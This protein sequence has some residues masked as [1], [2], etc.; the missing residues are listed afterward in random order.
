M[1]ALQSPGR[2][3]ISTLL[4]EDPM[5]LSTDTDPKLAIDEDIDIE[6]DEVLSHQG[7]DELMEEDENYEALEDEVGYGDLDIKNDEEMVDDLEIQ[8]PELS[9]MLPPDP[10]QA[11][12]YLEDE[13]LLEDE[14]SNGVE[15]HNVN[16][17]GPFIPLS[18]SGG[19][20]SPGS[21]LQ[22]DI[23]SD[24]H[25]AVYGEHTDREAPSKSEF[26][27][28]LVDAQDDANIDQTA[29]ISIGHRPH[30][31]H[32]VASNITSSEGHQYSEQQDH[33]GE[34][35]EDYPERNETTF[36]LEENNREYAQIDESSKHASSPTGSEG[37]ERY[38]V[39]VD[40]DPIE[41]DELQNQPEVIA[42]IPQSEDAEHEQTHRK[43]QPD[44]NGTTP[45]SGS[46]IGEQH[47]DDGSAVNTT[48]HQSTYLHPAIVV[49][50]D[51]E[52]FLFPPQ[53][54]NDQSQT[55][56]L[57]DES[58]ANE[59]MSELLQECRNLLG[60]SISEND[61]LEIEIPLLN[62]RLGEVSCHVCIFIVHALAYASAERR[63]TF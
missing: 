47:I 14:A 17:I 33:T 2:L 45:P 34:L 55:Y 5:E 35:D 43:S 56:F 62:L 18:V 39:P 26:G 63:S 38:A 21:A 44:P 19:N 24:S 10:A 3:D 9:E 50:Q 27:S 25:E 20:Q 41:G 48:A 31:N 53:Q 12:E 4:G 13:N 40:A 57:P 23:F 58:L 60:G 51:S 59:S 7:Q 8:Q 54:D 30:H 46:G 36:G 37:A 16:N 11:E 29:A 61:E 15:D 52:M 6:L 28:Q 22:E 32:P 42:T 1:T 49:Y